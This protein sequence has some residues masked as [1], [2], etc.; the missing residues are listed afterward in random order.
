MSDIWSAGVILYILLTGAPPFE[1]DNQSEIFKK[2]KTGKPNFDSKNIYNT[3]SAGKQLSL[4]VKD[5]LKKILSPVNKRI[6][7]E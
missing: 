2:I 1:G 3:D 5:L 6:N 7:L 4:L